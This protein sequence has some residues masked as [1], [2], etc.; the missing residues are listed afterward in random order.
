[1]ALMMPEVRSESVLAKVNRQLVALE[2]RDW[3]LWMILAGTGILVGAG[4]LAIL[5]PAANLKQGNMR[6]E[7]EVSREL[8]LGLVA[9]L[10]LFNTYVIG[11]RLELRRAREAVIS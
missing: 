2:K 7:I 6:I 3:E 5:F 4:L 9:L 8:F 1:M 11:R 10:T